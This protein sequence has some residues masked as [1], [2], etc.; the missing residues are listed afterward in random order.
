MPFRFK[1]T[2]VRHHL[3]EQG[4]EAVEVV[5]A[6][7]QVVDHADVGDPL[8]LQPLDDRDL[9]FRL[10]EPAAVV[11]ESQ[12]AAD[13]AGLFGERS[14]AWR[15]PPRPGALARARDPVGAEV[16]NDP[17]LGLQARGA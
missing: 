3:G 11:V 6:V 8:S 12:R 9:V 13:L 14:R 2:Q 4:G 5:V 17:E 1:A 7:V 16:E 15:P 10:A